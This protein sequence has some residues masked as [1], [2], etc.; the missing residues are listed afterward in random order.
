MSSTSEPL[1]A[2]VVLEILGKPPEHLVETLQELI[3]Q[4]KEEK[5][6]TI[7]GEKIH[8]ATEIEDNPGL[9]TT[10]VEIDVEVAALNHFIGFVFKYMP[11]HVEI[12]SP[13]NL[14]INNNLLNETFNE[15]TRRL[16]AYDQVA[17]VLQNEKAVLEKKLKDPKEK[18]R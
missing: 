7:K 11:A 18:K 1:L 10:F 9:Y 2:T 15:L 16:H 3:K 8:E 14:S 17:R 5:N 6:V 13:E 12:V 4:M